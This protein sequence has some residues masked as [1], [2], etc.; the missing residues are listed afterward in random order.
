MVPDAMPGLAYPGR[1]IETEALREIFAGLRVATEE[2]AEALSAALDLGDQQVGVSFLVE[3]PGAQAGP[4]GRIIDALDLAWRL[5]WAVAEMTEAQLPA[6]GGIVDL[7]RFLPIDDHG[8]EIEYVEIGSLKVWFKEHGAS[9]RQWIPTVLAI[10]SFMGVNP[11]DAIS[12]VLHHHGVQANVPHLS[13][14]AADSFNKQV[15]P[16][17]GECSVRTIIRLPNGTSIETV[18]RRGS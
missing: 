8:L 2:A 14:P 7:D 13:Q 16:L 15:P 10:A 6:S 11:H 12:S 9:I 4:A 3:L 17:P 18:L 1:E 5:G